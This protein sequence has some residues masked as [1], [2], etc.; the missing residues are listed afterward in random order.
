MKAILLT[1]DQ[2]TYVD[3]SDYQDLCQY[4][5]H[6]A[7]DPKTNSFYARR[8]GRV[9]GKKRAIAMHR[10]IMGFPLDLVDHKDNDSLNNQRSNLR[11]A[12]PSQNRQNQKAS[13]CNKTGFKGV[14]EH[15]T[16]HRFRAQIRVNHKYY[17]LG[18]HTT[19]EEASEAY[20]EAANRL[21]GEFAKY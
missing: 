19:A 9:D 14:Y 11:L 10:H 5:W 6:A 1:Q 18:F 12:T 20:K 17:D 15:P 13:A 8:S 3:D 21:H 2:I 16:T 4:K 7:W